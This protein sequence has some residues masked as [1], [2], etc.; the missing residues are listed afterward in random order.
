MV[1]APHNHWEQPHPLFVES[2]MKKDYV[3]YLADILAHGSAEEKKQLY[4]EN[5]GEIRKIQERLDKL[6]TNQRSV[7]RKAI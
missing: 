6:A 5:A 2:L 1:Y 4:K 3:E 7:K